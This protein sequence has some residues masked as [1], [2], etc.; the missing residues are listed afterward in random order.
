MTL[1][2]V[3]GNIV[4]SC[5]STGVLLCFTIFPLPSTSRCTCRSSFNPFKLFICYILSRVVF[6]IKEGNVI[7]DKVINSSEKLRPEC[8]ADTSELPSNFLG[9]IMPA[10]LVKFM[11]LQNATGCNFSFTL[12]FVLIHQFEQLI[13]V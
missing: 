9:Y 12:N 2:I 1:I 8:L 5:K 7:M 3:V 10:A 13:L 4:G 6:A 11:I